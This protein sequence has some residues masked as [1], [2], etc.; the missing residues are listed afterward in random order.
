MPLP[1]SPSAAELEAA[2]AAV[3]LEA[4]PAAARRLRCSVIGARIHGV[5]WQAIGD[6]LQVPALVAEQR[7]TAR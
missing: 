7:F 1:V 5:S 3:Y 6:A 2:G 4:I